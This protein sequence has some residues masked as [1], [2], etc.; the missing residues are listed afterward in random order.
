MQRFYVFKDSTQIGSTVTKEEAIA[1]I[2]QHQKRETHYMLRSEYSIIHGEEEFIP[3]V[4]GVEMFTIK[5]ISADG[6]YYLV[7]HWQKHKTYWIEPEKVKADMLFKTAA[8]AKRSLTKLLK[9]M[10]DYRSDKFE[11]VKLLA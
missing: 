5:S 10:E 2:R 8:D 9:V 11:V 6:T 1:M 7:N 4:K 3:Y